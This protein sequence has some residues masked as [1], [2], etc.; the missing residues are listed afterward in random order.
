MRRR[1]PLTPEESRDLLRGLDSGAS[2]EGMARRAIDAWERSAYE[3]SASENRRGWGEWF[4]LSR[5]YAALRPATL[6][7]LALALLAVALWY[8][9]GRTPTGVSDTA[10][11][12]AAQTAER[13]GA[14]GGA[15]APAPSVL[16][17][18]ARKAA[19]ST[20][21]KAMP[22]T[23][24]RQRVALTVPP[25][26]PQLQRYP[27]AQDASATGAV[28][29]KPSVTGPAEAAKTRGVASATPAVSE[30]E[31]RSAAASY[32]RTANADLADTTA[33]PELAYIN[34]EG[35]AAERAGN[36]RP[37]WADSRLAV[38]LTL[39]EESASAAD[40][41]GVVRSRTG[42]EIVLPDEAARRTLAIVCTDRALADV[43]R[44]LTRV[45]NIRWQIGGPRS[46]ARYIAVPQQSVASRSSLAMGKMAP[47]EGLAGGIATQSVSLKD[48]ARQKGLDLIGDPAA[49]RAALAGQSAA[50]PE[51]VEG[52]LIATG[53]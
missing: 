16:G 22:E 49:L 34:A 28:A 23:G 19:T 18:A 42:V 46:S 53:S 39:A 12:R 7:A 33:S 3:A 40:L 20:P 17:K 43:M 26:K 24:V 51:P 30:P 25:S 50:K 21:S 38:R 45:L 41:A 44:Q 32:G 14:P 52:W 31:A 36:G 29:M 13:L 48:L 2:P 5:L 9:L 47:P 1:A 35:P 15:P 4:V 8:Q 10:P 11:P 27:S 37:Q 6:G